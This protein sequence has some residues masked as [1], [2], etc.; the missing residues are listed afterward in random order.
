MRWIMRESRGRRDAPLSPI[1]SAEGSDPLTGVG[2][3]SFPVPSVLA[4]VPLTSAIAFCRG[5]AGEYAE[6]NEFVAVF[7]WRRSYRNVYVIE[8]GLQLVFWS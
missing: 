4:E 5:Y 1:G 8:L 6:S 2:E 3:G 7:D